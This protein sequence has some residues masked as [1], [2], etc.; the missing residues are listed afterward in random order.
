MTGKIFPDVATSPQAVQEVVDRVPMCSYYCTS[1]PV[2]R[3]EALRFQPFD[4]SP[5]SAEHA[6][7]I[8]NGSHRASICRKPSPSKGETWVSRAHRAIVI[9]TFRRARATRRGHANRSSRRQAPNPTS[10]VPF[11]TTR[12]T[13][14]IVKRSSAVDTALH[15]S[16]DHHGDRMYPARRAGDDG[17]QR[18]VGR[19]P[20]NE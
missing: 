17:H 4:S 6:A 18:Q 14:T 8:F 5:V 1:S 12:P 19:K 10:V 16:C 15:E 7:S 2:A 13:N 3:P 20:G 9:K 11:P